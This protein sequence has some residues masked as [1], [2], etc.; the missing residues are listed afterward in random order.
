MRMTRIGRSL[1]VGIVPKILMGWFNKPTMRLKSL[2]SSVKFE[3]EVI[4]WFCIPV[5]LGNQIG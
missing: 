4:I 5:V 3:S 1:T 2:V